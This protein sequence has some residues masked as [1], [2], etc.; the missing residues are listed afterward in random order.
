MEQC[1][2]FVLCGVVAELAKVKTTP[3]GIKVGRIYIKHAS[4]QAEAGHTRKVNCT[5][6]VVAAGDPIASRVQK[7]AVGT[8]VKVKGFVSRAGYRSADLSIEL[9]A[10]EIEILTE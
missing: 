8:Q 2:Q 5:V 7:L 4:D 10:D 9:H 1:N 3:A 6:R